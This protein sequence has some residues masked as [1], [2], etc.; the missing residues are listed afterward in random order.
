M[1]YDLGEM[2][3]IGRWFRINFAYVGFLI[4]LGLSVIYLMYGLSKLIFK[5]QERCDAKKASGEKDTKV[6]QEA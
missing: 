2:V 3:T 6:E 5:A 4:L 1:F